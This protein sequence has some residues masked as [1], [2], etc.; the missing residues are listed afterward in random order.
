MGRGHVARGAIMVDQVAHRLHLTEEEED[1]VHFLV[2]KHVILSDASRMRDVHEPSFLK[3][4]AERIA[5]VEN[6]DYLYC[7]TWC[8]A[9]AVGEGILTG[10]QEALLGE[11]YQA[12]AAELASSGARRAVVTHDRLLGALVAA[13]QD[14]AA[15]EAFLAG[16]PASYHHQVGNDEIVRHRR[17]HA[18]ALADGIGL[19]PEFRD[20]HV[21]LV[22][23]AR[24]RH[25]LFADLAATLSGHGF[26]VLDARTWVG[27]D[28]L[29]LYS[30][31]LGTIFPA[32]V[33][34]E[35]VWAALKRDLTA[36]VAGRLDARS[37]LDRR[38]K[39]YVERPADSGFDDPAVKVEGAT[40][41][42]H[43]IIDIHAKDEA[44]LL[45]RLCRTISDS[46]CEIGHACINTMGDVAVDVFYVQRAGRKLDDAEVDELRRRLI[47]AL[48]L[49]TA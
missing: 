13:G 36:V 6:L 29:V 26:D 46:G 47:A 33:R 41:E 14:R 40:S 17:V 48:D 23:A 27:A 45:S 12:V 11:L 32:R 39:A 37:L 44:G 20:S 30:F 31:R 18:E 25:A 42:S 38:R 21:H 1:L 9:K 2:E 19:H 34:E 10:W 15:S 49:K 7:L 35:A 16:L 8:D 22:A 5:S 43:T 3:P 4:F 24:D 28:G